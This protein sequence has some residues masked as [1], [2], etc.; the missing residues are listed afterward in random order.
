MKEAL[1]APNITWS[2]CN[3]QAFNTSAAP[4]TPYGDTSA[5]AIQGALPRVID[6]TQRVLIAGADF[7]MEVP[8]LGILLAIQNMT[9]GGKLGFQIEPQTLIDLELPDLEYN[10]VFVE[11]GFEAFDQP[12]QGIMGIQHF[13]RGLMWASTK[14]CGHM[15]PQFQ[16]RSSYRH[17]QWLLGKVDM[18]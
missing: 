14:L 15:Q 13:E 6:A 4:D 9:W 11:S 2:L 12:G 10:D 17:L 1:H 16:A 3:G 7:D 8:Q 18:L 5:D